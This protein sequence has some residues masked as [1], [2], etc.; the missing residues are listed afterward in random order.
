LGAPGRYDAFV[1]VFFLGRRRATFELLMRAAGVQPG[2][3]VLDVG[4]G[5]GYFAR[6]LAD[7]VGPDGL[8]VGIDASPEMIEYAN[9]KRGHAANCQFHVGAAEALS[10][11][12]EHFD[13]VVS[14]L[15]MHHLPADLRATALGDMRRVLRPGGT[16]LIAEAQVPRARVLRLVARVHG[17]D[18]MARAV[19]DLEG[20]IA[21]AEFEHLRSGEAPPW[22]RYVCAVKSTGV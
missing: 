5:T 22:L 20:L 21:N 19:P 12:P 2:Q 7:A 11:A 1:N 16:L 9:R 4:C 6:L 8:V 14:S 13:V 15:F 3:R 18:R 10:F 17:Y